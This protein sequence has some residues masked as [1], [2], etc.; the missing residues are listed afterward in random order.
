MRDIRFRAWDKNLKEMAFVDEINWKKGIFWANWSKG[1]AV[2]RHL[3]L[4][5]EPSLME[6]TGLLDKNGVEIYEGDIV[7]TPTAE[8]EVKFE[9]GKF[10]PID[11]S[12]EYGWLH[13]QLEV[14]G[15]IYENKELLKET[16]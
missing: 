6:F 8:V 7:K 10:E 12:G 11:A 14:I 2:G 4:S 9:Y 1:G 5:F 13:N 16:K 15:N 3:E